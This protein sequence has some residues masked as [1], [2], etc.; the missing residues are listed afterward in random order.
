MQSKGSRKLTTNDHDTPAVMPLTCFTAMGRNPRLDYV[1]QLR[2]GRSRDCCRGPRGHD[3][4]A[5]QRK[6]GANDDDHDTPAVR[7]LPPLRPWVDTLGELLARL[8]RGTLQGPL[9]R[10]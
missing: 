1:A 6:Q 5:E 3:H 8:R 2:R 9:P 4:D 7:L 10:S